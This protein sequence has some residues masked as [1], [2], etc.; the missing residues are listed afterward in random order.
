MSQLII[1]SCNI[2]YFQSSSSIAYLMY[3]IQMIWKWFLILLLVFICFCICNGGV[4]NGSVCLAFFA[5]VDWWIWFVFQIDWWARLSQPIRTV[6]WKDWWCGSWFCRGYWDGWRIVCEEC[7][8]CFWSKSFIFMIE[9]RSESGFKKIMSCM[10]ILIV[11]L[12]IVFLSC[13]SYFTSF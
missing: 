7:L 2:C 8:R 10:I 11:V 1:F 13:A 12:T 6:H 5:D 3:V 9:S 4:C